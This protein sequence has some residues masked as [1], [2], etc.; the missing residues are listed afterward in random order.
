MARAKLQKKRSEQQ[1][2]GRQALTTS[3]A[4]RVRQMALREGVTFVETYADRF[5]HA[6]TRLAGDEVQSDE[7]DNLLVALRRQG[8]IS[9]LEMV[10]MMAEHHRALKHV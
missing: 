5:A 1:L 6:A 10:R 8:K 7:T 9:P 4:R 3:I 2:G